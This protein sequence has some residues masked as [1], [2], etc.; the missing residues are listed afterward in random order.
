MTRGR[1]KLIVWGPVL[2]LMALIFL[3]SAQPKS[4]PPAYANGVYFSGVMPIFE[5]PS[6]DALIKK[7]AHMAGYGLLG[8][9]IMRGL[10]AQGL[11]SREAAYFAILLAVSYALTDELH[12]AFVPGRHA[13]VLDI[14]IDYVGAASACLLARRL[15]E[16]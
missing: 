7:G 15:V 9:L 2:V 10:L 14:G 12:Q 13:T 16:A 4:A 3:F 6:L 5:A 1:D 11:S 8:V